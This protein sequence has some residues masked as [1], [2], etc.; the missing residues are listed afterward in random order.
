[1]PQNP[2][3]DNDKCTS[4]TGEVRLLPTGGEG[5]MILCFACYLHELSWRRMRNKELGKAAVFALPDWKSL[6]VYGGK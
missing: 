5:N 2:N 4:A 3:C 6:K 1:M